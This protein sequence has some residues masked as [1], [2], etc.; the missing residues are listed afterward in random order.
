MY[1]NKRYADGETKSFA[2]NLTNVKDSEDDGRYLEYMPYKEFTELVKD[3]NKS[4]LNY[5]H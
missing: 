4:A 3:G 5:F 1:K 2:G